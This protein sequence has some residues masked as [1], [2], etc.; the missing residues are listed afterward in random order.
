MKIFFG[1]APKQ[2]AEVWGNEGTFVMRDNNWNAR[3]FYFGVEY[4]SNNGGLEEVVLFD[5]ID[6]KVPVPIENI[7][8]LITA[9]Q[10][11]LEL[12]DNGHDDVAMSPHVTTYIESN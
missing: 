2:D 5:G 7:L 1:E 11:V 4:G 9:L 8:E 6:R 10:A 12:Y 3:Y